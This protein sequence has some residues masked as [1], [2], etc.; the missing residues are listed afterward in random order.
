MLKTSE[1]KRLVVG[2]IDVQPALR[3]DWS[4]RIDVAVLI[5]PLLGDH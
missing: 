1:T 5:G 2:A 3:Q 4:N